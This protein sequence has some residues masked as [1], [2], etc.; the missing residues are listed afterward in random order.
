MLPLQLVQRSGGVV[1][2]G[3]KVGDVGGPINSELATGPMW[4]D[5]GEGVLVGRRQGGDGCT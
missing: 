3:P 2:E 5:A 4:N 1:G